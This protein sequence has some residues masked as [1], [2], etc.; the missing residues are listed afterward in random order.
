MRLS[1]VRPLYLGSCEHPRDMTITLIERKTGVSSIAPIHLACLKDNP[2]AVSTL[3][4]RGVNINA[5]TVGQWTPLFIACV[6]GH[7]ETVISLLEWGADVNDY[8]GTKWTAMHAA[9][10]RPHLE[11]ARALLKYSPYV[12]ATTTMGETPL[13]F[14][15]QVALPELIELLLAHG[16]DPNVVDG[17]GRSCVDWASWSQPCMVA[18]ESSKIPPKHTDQAI[19]HAAL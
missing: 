8:T 16:Y 1:T 3:Y 6:E 14:A 4:H 18:V 15:C 11:I 12:G 7:T 19:S 5:R 10:R 9:C 2:G 17:Y 13:H